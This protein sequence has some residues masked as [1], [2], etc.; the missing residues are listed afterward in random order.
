[1]TKRFAIMRG[2]SRNRSAIVLGFVLAFFSAVSAAKADTGNITFIGATGNITL[3][4]SD[5]D[6]GYSNVNALID[7]YKATINGSS[8]PT[9]VFCVD[10]AHDVTPGESWIFNVYTP[11]GN[12]GT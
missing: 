10:P 3:N 2:K 5:A 6:A 12:L 1:M 7:P 4:V 11:G 8:S 9:L